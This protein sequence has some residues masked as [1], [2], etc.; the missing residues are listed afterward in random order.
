MYLSKT[1]QKEWARRQ[2][3]PI[4][5]WGWTS[6]TGLKI[7]VDRGYLTQVTNPVGKKPPLYGAQ[8]LKG[9]HFYRADVKDLNKARI[10]KRVSNDPEKA[11]VSLAKKGHKK[12][13]FLD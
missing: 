7:K 9:F 2:G 10:V 12:V 5:A 8:G 1:A 3:I 4:G 11:M 13:T 6:K